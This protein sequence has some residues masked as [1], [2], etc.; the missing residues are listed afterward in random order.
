MNDHGI[1]DRVTRVRDRARERV[2][3]SRVEK[4]D[5]DNERLRTEVGLL[6]GDL[7]EERSSFKDALKALDARAATSN[8][9]RRPHLFRTLVIAGGAY[10]LGTRDGRER[11]NQ[12]VRRVRALSE[13][14]KH[15]L[16]ERDAHD[17]D[18]SRPEGDAIV[19][20]PSTSS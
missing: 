18:A 1:T 14:V 5:R 20:R 11:Y 16:D 9:G 4:L 10:V 3:H 12:I 6:R 19:P 2:M 13:G 17:W 8:N 7:E 15:R